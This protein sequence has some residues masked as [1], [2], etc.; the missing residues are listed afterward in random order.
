[1]QS[2]RIQF[3]FVVTII[4]GLLNLCAVFISVNV[5]D[6]M[7][8]EG[9]NR[10]KSRNIT[11]YI[12]LERD[13]SLLRPVAAAPAKCARNGLLWM[14]VNS[15]PGNGRHRQLIRESWAR[16]NYSFFGQ[17]H[18]Q[19]KSGVE[20]LAALGRNTKVSVTFFIGRSLNST[21]QQDVEAE[22]TQ[23]GDILQEDL[24]DHYQNMTLKTLQMLKWANMGC[25]K[26]CKWLFDFDRKL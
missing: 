1:M 6:E 11:D 2:K 23:H 21:V 15:A 14:F 17:I 12:D 24:I 18:R 9:W 5:I 3:I 26:S 19:Q 22:H 8:L 25:I 7:Q 10:N 16:L 13:T 20:Y 4:Y